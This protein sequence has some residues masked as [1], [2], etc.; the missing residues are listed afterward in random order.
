M[1]NAVFTALREEL[2]IRGVTLGAH[3]KLIS[4]WEAAE[5]KN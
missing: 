4:D 1:Y 2:Q 5:V 3:Y